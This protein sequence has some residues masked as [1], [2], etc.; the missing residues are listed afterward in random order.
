[1]K[2]L[3]ALERLAD[4]HRLLAGCGFESEE[5]QLFGIPLWAGARLILRVVDSPA[6]SEA[7]DAVEVI[8]IRES[9]V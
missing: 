4:V 7:D 6:G 8:D 2:E 1:M 3:E 9:D 5:P